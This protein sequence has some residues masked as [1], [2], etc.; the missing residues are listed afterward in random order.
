LNIETLEYIN[1]DHHDELLERLLGTIFHLTLRGN[2]DQII[3]DKYVG[4][5]R[6]ERYKLNPGSYGSFGR[7]RGWVSLF[8]LREE[9]QETIG[10]ISTLYFLHSNW[11]FTQNNPDSEEA[12]LAYLL[13]SED[14]S[15]RLI[16]N[17][18]GRKEQVNSGQGGQIIPK[19]E[20]WFPGDMSLDY[21]SH[22]LS[23]KIIRKLSDREKAIK[24]AHNLK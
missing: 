8:E 16:T 12:N 11:F 2:L 18:V 23:V 10:E 6:E 3:K 7:K 9:S 4:H 1:Q 21:I 24:G 15:H 17:A 14:E 5:N 19:T 13:F 22:A 20:C